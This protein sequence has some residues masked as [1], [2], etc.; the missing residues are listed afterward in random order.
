MSNKRKTTDTP[1]VIYKSSPN[2]FRKESPLSDFDYEKLLKDPRSEIYKKTFTSQMIQVMNIEGLIAQTK[3]VIA[4]AMR[5]LEIFFAAK[6]GGG[7]VNPWG[8]DEADILDLQNQTG[9]LDGAL[10]LLKKWV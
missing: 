3:M 5:E 1:W 8:V 4:K 7:L 9:E 2:V 6:A 10:M